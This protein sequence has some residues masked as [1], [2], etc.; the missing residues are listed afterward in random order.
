MQRNKKQETVIIIVTYNGKKWIYKCLES[1]KICGIKEQSIIVIDNASTDN[2]LDIIKQE[3]SNVK[4]IASNK[5]LGFG[6][7]NNIGLKYAL[8]LKADYVFLLNQDAYI[9]DET[10]QKLIVTH[11]KNPEYGIIS[12]IHL[13]KETKLDRNFKKYITSDFNE[14]IVSDFI[15]GKQT[16]EIYDVDFINA[17][18]WLIPKSTLEKVGGF[19]P[20]FNHYGEDDNFIQRCKYHNI[21]IGL[22]PNTYIIHDRSQ[23]PTNL[24]NYSFKKYSNYV[25][26]HILCEIT[27]PNIDAIKKCEKV[28]IHFIKGI[29]RKPFATINAFL[30]LSMK[31]KSIW[32]QYKKSKISNN[33]FLN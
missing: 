12:P 9:I 7:A 29:I 3:F 4:L 14:S 28:L 15:L 8:D 6:K 25:Y 33:N 10:I 32:N 30:N 16:K 24:R 20:V 5:N 23:A 31:S 11:T 26:S 2:T 27:N 18:A 13:S 19:M 1:L 21:K 17:A 22:A